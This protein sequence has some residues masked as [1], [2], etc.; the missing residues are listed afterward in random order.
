[1]QHHAE[2][3]QIPPFTFKSKGMHGNK[4]T[5]E[6]PLYEKPDWEDMMIDRE[7]AEQQLVATEDAPRLRREESTVEKD[8]VRHDFVYKGQ[9]QGAGLGDREVFW[10][11]EDR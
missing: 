4:K 8:G 6:K 3:D 5:V 9:E 10:S 11:K 7:V 2:D 1:M